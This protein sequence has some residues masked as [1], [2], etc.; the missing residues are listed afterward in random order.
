[1][2]TR[3]HRKVLLLFE[4]YGL[5]PSRGKWSMLMPVLLLSI[6]GVY[7]WLAIKWNM[8]SFDGWNEMMTYAV[9]YFTKVPM[10]LMEYW[11]LL[12]TLFKMN[13]ISEVYKQIDS[14]DLA[15][16]IEFGKAIENR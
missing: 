3:K 10:V 7:L 4:V 8:L 13:A 2:F 1:M 12:I 14:F 5:L 11:I 15:I 6:S 9:Y 16:L